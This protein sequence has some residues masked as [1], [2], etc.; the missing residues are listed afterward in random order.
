M[1][2]WCAPA[3]H[4]VRAAL[5]SAAGWPDLPLALHLPPPLPGHG[6]SGVGSPA[7]PGAALLPV[8]RQQGGAGIQLAA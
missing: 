7:G 4:V 3:G 2:S 1:T 8:Q 6:G 5:A